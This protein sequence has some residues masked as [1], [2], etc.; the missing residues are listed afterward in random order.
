MNIKSDDRVVLTLDA[1]GTNFIFSA[2][3]GGVEVV[4]PIRRPAITYNLEQC[5]NSLIK[6]L[7][8]VQERIG[9][10]SS[11]IS[12][13]FPGPANYPKGIIGDLPNFPCFKGGVPMKSILENEFKQPVFI[14]NDGDLFAYGEAVGGFLPNVNKILKEKG[15]KKE[16]KNL[17]GVTLGTGFGIGLSLNGELFIGDNSS[18][19]EVWCT[20]SRHIPYNV[21]EGVSVRSIKR[22]YSQLTAKSYANSPE[23]KEIYDIAKGRVTGNQQAAKEAFISLGR[24]LGDTLANIMTF[25]DGGLAVISGGIS[26]ANDI[27]IPA[28]LKEMNATYTNY[29]GEIIPRLNQKVYFLNDKLQM[30]NFTKGE[31]H[32][33]KIPNSRETITYDPISKIGIGLSK[34]GASKSISL[35]AYAFA[36]KNI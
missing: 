33:I 1:G 10:P 4:E 21:E 16:Y 15:C 3:Q 22:V 31:V 32:K 28:M 9:K 14:N 12:F 24:V 35:G 30:E 11:A 18:G 36:L 34:I 19:P 13:A 23:P 17:L 29:R 27:I 7:H 6:G 5:M 25:L 20:S 26:G 2:I 8:Q